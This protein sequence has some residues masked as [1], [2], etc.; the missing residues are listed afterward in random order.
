[1]QQRYP[2]VRFVVQRGALIAWVIPAVIAIAG[3][4]GFALEW[5]LWT[6]GGLVAGAAVLF[7]VLRVVVELIQII[8]ETLL[9]Q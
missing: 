7:C 6:S 8:A 4:F 3:L 9:P 5:G 1:M 2:A